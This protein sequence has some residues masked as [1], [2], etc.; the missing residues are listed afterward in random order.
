MTS[1]DD[2]LATAVLRERLG[3]RLSMHETGEHLRDINVVWSLVQTPRDVFTLMPTGS[4]EEW[5]TIATRLEAVPWTL[6]TVIEAYQAGVDAELL[7]ARR[8]VVGAARVAAV[9]AGLESESDGEP[10]SW[11]EDYVGAYEG[12]DD[13][14]RSR[15]GTGAVAATGAYARLAGWL[16]ESYAPKAVEV[17]GVGADRYVRLARIHSGIDLDL[18]ETYAW[19]WEDL[20][21]IMTR[22]NACAARLYGGVSPA[23]AQS[24]LDI[25]PEHTIEGAEQTRDW[26]QQITDE[27]IASFNGQYFEIPEQMLVCEATLAPPGGGAMPYYTPSEDFSRPGRTWLPV[28]GQKR[29]ST[30]WLTAAWYHEAVPG[31]HLQVAYTM[32][33]K[34]RLSRFQR[35]E[36]VSGHGEGWALYAERLMD[37]LGYYHDP[38]VELGYLSGQAIRACRVILDIGLHLDLPIPANVAPALFDGI[39]GD[40]RGGHWDRELARQFLSVRGIVP[41]GYAAKEVDRYLGWPG[42]AICYKV[43]ERAWLAARED[44][45]AREGAAFDLKAWHMRALALG[46][47]GLDVLRDELARI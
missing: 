36:F 9:A 40:P 3:A 47:V 25:D 21:R 8:Q 6:C 26:L 44:A 33:Q 7:P 42:Q 34:Q 11:F 12:H 35:V 24:R 18:P 45:R 29:F 16:R 31:H 38:A 37:E 27:T 32:T 4:D 30:W 46:S 20:A 2:R 19:G 23:E 13:G 5:S 10:E 15:L 22:M 17:D 43:G 28:T 14:L 41:D 1:D 39:Q